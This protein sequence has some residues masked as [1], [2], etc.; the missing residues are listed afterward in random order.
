MLQF[1][2]PWNEEAEGATGYRL[3][4]PLDD[5]DAWVL[6][7]VEVA[8]RSRMPESMPARDMAS[9]VVVRSSMSAL[10]G[11]ARGCCGDL[12]CLMAIDWR[13]DRLR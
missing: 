11:G 12:D 4:E 8:V 6:T 2:S 5:G 10:P 7:R 9:R 13:G 1:S 3:Q